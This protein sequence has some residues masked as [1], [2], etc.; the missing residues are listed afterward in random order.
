MAKNEVAIFKEGVT[1]EGYESLVFLIDPGTA[2][3]EE[4]AELFTEMSKL[5]Q[6]LSGV[7]LKFR[8]VE[9]DGNDD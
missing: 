9:R 5:C 8:L 4:I 2:S 3:A 1:R 6:M 7:G